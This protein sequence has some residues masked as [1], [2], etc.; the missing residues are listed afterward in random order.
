M[1]PICH[2]DPVWVS[3]CHLPSPGQRICSMHCLLGCAPTG[4][5]G[6]FFLHLDVRCAVAAVAGYGEQSLLSL[7]T[8]LNTEFL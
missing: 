4:G 6:V 7:P 8:I 1:A 2:Q 3:C 5:R